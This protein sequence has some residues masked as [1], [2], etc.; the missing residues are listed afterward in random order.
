M[1]KTAAASARPLSPLSTQVQEQWDAT[2]WAKKLARK[3]TRANLTDFERF[4]LMVARKQKA[5]LVKAKM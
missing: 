5:A 2:T 3:K 1:L 4:K